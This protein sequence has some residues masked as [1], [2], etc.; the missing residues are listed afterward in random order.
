MPT[1]WRDIP[2]VEGGLHANTPNFK[3]LFVR[4]LQGQLTGDEERRFSRSLDLYPELKAYAESYEPEPVEIDPLRDMRPVPD[5]T[6]TNPLIFR[7]YM[8]LEQGP[9]PEYDEPTLDIRPGLLTIENPEFYE[10]SDEDQMKAR[11]WYSIDPGRAKAEGLKPPVHRHGNVAGFTHSLMSGIVGAPHEPTRGADPMVETVASLIGEGIKYSG[12]YKYL[13]GLG[14]SGITADIAAGGISGGTRQ[15]QAEEP[16]LGDAGVEALIVGATGGL[17]RAAS[18]GYS[19][20][21]WDDFVDEVVKGH[22]PQPS[23]DFKFSEAAKA[24]LK[25]EGPFTTGRKPKDVIDDFL[26]REDVPPEMRAEVE[27]NRAELEEGLASFDDKLAAI[28]KK[29]REFAGEP[30]PPAE[31]L[32]R[33]LGTDLTSEAG[34]QITLCMWG[35]T[36]DA[37]RELQAAWSGMV[38][39]GVQR[40]VRVIPE[41]IK[42]TMAGMFSSPAPKEVQQ[43]IKN[44][45]KG[46]AA[47]KAEAA[48][49]GRMIRDNIPPEMQ[50]EALKYLDPTILDDPGTLWGYSTHRAPTDA[51]QVWTAT[52]N[53]ARQRIDDLS[54]QFVGLDL[55]SREKYLETVGE[56]LRRSYRRNDRYGTFARFR[57][58][59]LIK[60]DE[61]KGRKLTTPEEREAAGIILD[62]PYAVSRTIGD[63]TFDLEAAKMLRKIGQNP[64]WARPAGAFEDANL[65]AAEDFVR[66][67]KD[68]RYGDL[69]DMWVKRG[70]MAELEGLI[71]VS[72]AGTKGRLMDEL[73]DAYDIA[74]SGWK[75]GKTAL[76]PATHGRNVLS[77]VVLADL[78]GLSPY[79]VDIYAKALKDYLSKGPLYQEAAETGLL[80]TDWFG[81]EIQGYLEPFNQTKNA[82]MVR[83]V[84]ELA[85][86]SVVAKGVKKA[87]DLYQGEEHWF[88]L[89]LYA[90][91]RSLGDTPMRAAAHAQKYL[92]DYSDISPMM[93]K[94]RQSPFGGPFLSFTYKSLPVIVE[95]AVKHPVRFWKWPLMFHALNEGSKHMIGMTDEQYEAMQKTLPDWQKSTFLTPKVLLPTRGVGGKP[96]V[97]DL[98]YNL[99]WGQVGEQGELFKRL[100]VLKDIPGGALIDPFVGSNPFVNT[101]IELVTNKNMFTGKEIFTPGVDDQIPGDLV[102][103]GMGGG[104]TENI[105]THVYRQM[106]PGIMVNAPSIY[107]AATGGKHRTGEKM[108]IYSTV[109]SKIAGI[110][111]IEVDEANNLRMAQVLLKKEQEK[112]VKR[113]ASIRYNQSKTDEEK[114]A[115]IKMLELVAKRLEAQAKELERLKKQQGKPAKPKD[116]EQDNYELLRGY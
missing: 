36:P 3:R 13:A 20:G 18:Q 98:T 24:K 6:A 73:Q 49:V 46:R 2:D 93:R 25:T 72:R 85:S 53:Q 68:I 76:N 55:L 28:E 12:I 97:L 116:T 21:K 110:K 86:N 4:G 60:G 115:D 1:D 59:P 15:I 109:L 58:K 90:H 102:P 81:A 26:A 54:E 22:P 10:Q 94:L 105:L 87:G 91:R 61:L 108:D 34:Q 107:K 45:R 79:R 71:P 101:A 47:G 44:V 40:M 104:A 43:L 17:I 50:T 62:A 111:I 63:L 56:Y 106:A 75:F 5:A 19:A 65:A 99:P 64:E 74:L 16:S 78:G 112:L 51:E 52:L 66:A 77:N 83:R 67:P 27:A 88:K 35:Y 7:D 9:E 114:L 70:V 39:R 96:R 103:Q 29:N 11:F 100:P 69:S 113:L 30:E 23:G 84:W 41:R 95:S 37:A 14:I 32:P 48:Q 89:A 80:G 8:T 38:D 31:G 42:A 82:G 33:D 57:S 92:F